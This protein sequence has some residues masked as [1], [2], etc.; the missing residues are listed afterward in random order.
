MSARRSPLRVT[1]KPWPF[2]PQPGEKRHKPIC[3]WVCRPGAVIRGAEFASRAAHGRPAGYWRAVLHPS[4]KEPGRWQVS[5]FDPEGAWGDSVRSTCNAAL[6]ARE[7]EPGS[8][9]LVAFE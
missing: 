7:I 4:T 1:C 8:W 3:K 5:L 2:K 9:K 6:D